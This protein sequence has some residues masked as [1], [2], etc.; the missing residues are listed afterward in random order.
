MSLEKERKRV[1]ESRK[2]AESPSF[3][4][5]K[6]QSESGS[7]ITL[8]EFVESNVSDT[9]ISRYKS[10]SSNTY[11]KESSFQD[12]LGDIGSADEIDNFDTTDFSDQNWSC[13]EITTLRGVQVR[14]VR[15]IISS[16]G[17]K[18]RQDWNLMGENSNVIFL[19]ESLGI[20][21]TVAFIGLKRIKTQKRIWEF[22]SGVE[23]MSTE[24]CYYWHAKIRSPDNPGAVKALRTLLSDP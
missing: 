19:T 22:A 7:E 24:E 4:L 11:A 6:N 16:L 1:L 8:Y 14:A 21:A 10:S 13:I 15:S 20:R 5:V 2:N 23:N 12:A 9:R 3:S 17:E 18:I